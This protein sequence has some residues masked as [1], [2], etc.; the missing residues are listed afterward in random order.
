MSAASLAVSSLAWAASYNPAPASRV[1]GLVL[2]PQPVVGLAQDAP[3]GGL[4]VGGRLE[5]I[6]EGR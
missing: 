5:R 6:G 4:D 1:R 3:G 2:L